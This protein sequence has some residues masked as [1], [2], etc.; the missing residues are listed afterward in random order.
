MAVPIK[1]TADMSDVRR[2]FDNLKSDAAR[3]V[4]LGG[5]GGPGVTGGPPT[6]ATILGQKMVIT[7]PAWAAALAAAGVGSSAG[8]VTSAAGGGGFGQAASVLSTSPPPPIPAMGAEQGGGQVAAVLGGAGTRGGSFNVGQ[9]GGANP[10]FSST[11]F[12]RGFTAVGAGFLA[13]MGFKALEAGR[14]YSIESALAGGDQRAE[15][16]A[17]MKYRTGLMSSFGPF[18]KAAGLI[19]DPTG[20]GEAGIRATVGEAD[21]QD[22][23]TSARRATGQARLSQ[24]G[25][26][27]VSGTTDPYER[28]LRA[29]EAAHDQE[30]RQITERQRAQEKADNEVI[31]KRKARL[32]AD[33]GDDSPEADAAEIG[34][35]RDQQAEARRGF[36]EDRSRE[37]SIHLR[38]TSEIRRGQGFTRL[39]SDTGRA[40][41]LRTL[42]LEAQGNTIGANR[43]A[44]VNQNNLDLL[45]SAS[46]HD[47]WSIGKNIYDVGQAKLAALDAA[48]ARAVRLGM[49]EARTRLDV[50]NA[51]LEHDP[52][53]ARL[54]SIR[55]GVAAELQSPLAIFSKDYARL[56]KSGGQQAENLAVQEDRE[57]RD[58]RD[59]A[60]SNRGA[61]LQTLLR[62]DRYAGVAANSLAIK[63]EAFLRVQEL[64]RTN[65]GGRNNSAIRQVLSNSQTEQQLLVKNL[66]GTF[67]PQSISISQTDLS[68]GGHGG[69]VQKA[70]DDIAKNTAD[71]SKKLDNLGKAL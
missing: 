25:R 18:G 27:S 29:S 56:V 50:T 9:R 6:T 38:E 71:T 46:R 8:G 61:Y 40:G 10:T 30:M 21:A 69:N 64:G 37:E 59:T 45:E 22:A 67:T 48:D 54:K 70:L 31:E 34:S 19:Q 52:L 13:N 14:E 53:E 36:A 11:F 49:T 60:L 32:K 15:L 28:R 41:S 16:D 63:D 66:I 7:N 12:G 68:G 55:G 51:E 43:A 47:E 1:F 33:H 65:G 39:L 5:G 2:S 20:S 23:Q 26:E 57:R 17:M 3:G 44:L 35:L 24:L 4:Q 42:A 62:D 58:L